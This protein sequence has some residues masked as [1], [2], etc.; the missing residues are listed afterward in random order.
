VLYQLSYIPVV[1]LV[2]VKVRLN[3]MLLAL[4]LR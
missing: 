1:F 2:M 3:C 4:E